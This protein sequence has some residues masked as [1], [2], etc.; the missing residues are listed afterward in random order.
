MNIWWKLRRLWHHPQMMRGCA[1]YT[2]SIP[3]ILWDGEGIDI[4]LFRDLLRDKG[5]RKLLR[6]YARED[7]KAIMRNVPRFLWAAW[8]Y[9]PLCCNGD[10]NGRD[11]S[12]EFCDWLENKARD[13]DG[14]DY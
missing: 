14:E 3:A 12:R 5:G 9:L 11:W 1:G 10:A 8:S 13:K 4:K 7:A 6:V 2:L